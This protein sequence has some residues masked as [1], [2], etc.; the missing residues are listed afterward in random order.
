MRLVDRKQGLVHCPRFRGIEVIT[1]YQ[2]AVLDDIFRDVVHHIRITTW[3][4]EP[5][6]ATE[7]S[8]KLLPIAPRKLVGVAS[9]VVR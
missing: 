3:Y 4:I 7:L 5:S 8:G 6:P 2:V 9:I 1:N